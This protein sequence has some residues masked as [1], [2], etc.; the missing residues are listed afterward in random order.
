MST[1]DKVEVIKKLILEAE[2]EN[3]LAV[4]GRLLRLKGEVTEIAIKRS[5]FEMIPA[6]AYYPVVEYDKIISEIDSQLTM[7]A[8]KMLE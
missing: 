3:L 6:C 4:K 8:K 7:L 5:G 1:S 2:M